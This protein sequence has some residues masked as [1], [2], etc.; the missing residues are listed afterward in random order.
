MLY[1]YIEILCS[2]TCRSPL[3]VSRTVPD[4]MMHCSG[5]SKAVTSAGVLSVKRGHFEA[6]EREGRG[7]EGTGKGNEDKGR[8]AWERT[9]L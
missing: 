8:K 1:H 2:P 9:H 6:G 7:K 4:C 3:T 5:G